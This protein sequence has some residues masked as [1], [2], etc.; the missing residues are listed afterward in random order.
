M[1]LLLLVFQSLSLFYSLFL[2]IPIAIGP[3][4]KINDTRSQV[5]EVYDETKMTYYWFFSLQLPLR[6]SLI[7]TPSPR[8]A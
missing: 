1:K 6:L 7:H 8:D 4:R 5:V 3:H 2:S